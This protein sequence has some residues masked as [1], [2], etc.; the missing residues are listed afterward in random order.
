MF[1]FVF[2]MA[3]WNMAVNMTARDSFAEMLVNIKIFVLDLE[4]DFM[5]CTAET[6]IS[7]SRNKKISGFL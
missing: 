1:M 7:A 4:S 5:I 6:V 2:L 3:M